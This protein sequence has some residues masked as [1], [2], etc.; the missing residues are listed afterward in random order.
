MILKRKSFILRDSTWT[1]AQSVTTNCH[2]R[3]TF[4]YVS[5]SEVTKY[6]KELKRKKSDGIDG[7]PACLLKDCAC[8]VAKPLAHVI[9]ISLETSIIPSDFKIGKVIPI[10][11][12][13]VKTMLDNY[14][15]ITILPIA[16][17][18]LEKCVYN[19]LINYLESNNL[20]SRNQF[21]FRKKHSTETAATFSWMTY[22]KP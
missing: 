16:S 9:N 1:K 17:K 11:K 18:I 12:N 5:V 10:Y 14:R 2:S 15:P 7:I 8:E 3:F 4:T 22:I 19:Q 20:L 13:G 6:L 21:G